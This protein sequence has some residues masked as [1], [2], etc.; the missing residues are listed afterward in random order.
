[1]TVKWK[2]KEKNERK[3]HTQMNS[4]SNT[5]RE[6]SVWKP[7]KWIVV[8][9]NRFYDSYIKQKVTVNVRPNTSY[10]I[11]FVCRTAWRVH[12]FSNVK[13]IK[14][15]YQL[16]LSAVRVCWRLCLV[17]VPCM[18]GPSSP[19][20]WVWICARME[21]SSSCTCIIIIIIFSL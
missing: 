1:M 18:N 4:I 14:K 11:T 13:N 16:I 2:E 21:G 5:N 6:E 12:L 15:N 3:K 7:P 9:Q 20:E 17:P 8:V 10:L 19:Y